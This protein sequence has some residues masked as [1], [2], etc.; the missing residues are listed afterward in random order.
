MPAKKD[1]SESRF[2][3]HHGWMMNFYTIPTYLAID[4][5]RSSHA[6]PR[7]YVN[8]VADLKNWLDPSIYII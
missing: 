4:K 5:D 3:H 2:L 8:Q 7:L 6:Y 1:G